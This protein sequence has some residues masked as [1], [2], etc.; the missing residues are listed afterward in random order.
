MLVYEGRRVKWKGRDVIVIEKIG[1]RVKVVSSKNP[2]WVRI[3]KREELEP[4]FRW[5]ELLS[6]INDCFL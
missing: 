4:R 2:K 1:N 5:D 6:R 3:V